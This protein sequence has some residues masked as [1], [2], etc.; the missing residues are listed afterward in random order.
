M[1]CKNESPAIREMKRAYPDK[2]LPVDQILAHI[3]AGDRIFIGTGC[4]EP[5]YLVQALTGYVESHPEAFSDAEALHVWTLG[6][7]P[8]TS[9]K[10]G[11]NFRRNSFFIG[12]N[13]RQAVNAGLDNYIP[14]FLSQ[15]P[16]LLRRHTVPI[17]VALIQTCPPDAHGFMSLGISVDIVKAAVE[18][19]SLVIAQ[20]NS[21]MPR[22]HGDSFV[23]I[24][25]MD[26]ILPY[27]EPLLEY[28]TAL[29]DE[30]VR[31]MGKYVSNVVEDGDTIQVGYGSIPSAVISCLATKHDLGVH[32]ELLTDDIVSL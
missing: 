3:Q 16:D 9:E 22:V 13:I 14:V 27:D 15:V 23:H 11:S 20:V 19:A 10:F 2:F 5:Q 4:G 24:T 12:S 21:H 29:P 31:G 32:S 1:D 30:T 6:I 7:D 8:Y 17:D 25:D 18:M 26:F 28:E